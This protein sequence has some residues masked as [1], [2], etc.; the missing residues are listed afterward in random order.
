MPTQDELFDKQRKLLRRLGDAAKNLAAMRRQR[1]LNDEFYD[2][3]QHSYERELWEIERSLDVTYNRTW[4]MMRK[5]SKKK[6]PDY[7][8]ETYE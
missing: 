8:K 7:L 2:H 5:Q 3:L 4:V 1:Q 6:V